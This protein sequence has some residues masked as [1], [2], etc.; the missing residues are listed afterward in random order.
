MKT[1]RDH[2]AEYVAVRRAFG[3]QLR[4]QAVTLGHFIN[5]LESQGARS[6]TTKLAVDWARKPERAQRATW[7][8]RLSMVRGFASWLSVRHP[9]TEVPPRGLMEARHRRNSPYIHTEAEIQ[10]LMAEAMDL[11]SSKGLRGLTLATLAGLMA[12]TGLR[13]GEAVALELNDVDLHTQVLLI[14]QSKFGKSRLVPIHDSTRHALAQYAQQRDQLHPRR[15]TTRF[16]VSDRGTGL[17]ADTIRRTF[18]KISRAIGL[19]QQQEGRRIGRGPR[20]QDLRHTFATERLV[21][22]YRAGLNAGRQ[23]PKLA[24]YLGHASVGNTC[25]YIEAVPGLL[26][27]ASESRFHFT[28]GGAQ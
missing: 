27:L 26:G 2:L 17:H 4:E 9:R 22:W 13:P 19:R 12:C 14:R 25:W 18:A 6:I 7:A 20:L 16:F 23:M 28:Q 3:A 1:L 15:Q 21:E 5:Y 8:R 11:P 10:R 24:T